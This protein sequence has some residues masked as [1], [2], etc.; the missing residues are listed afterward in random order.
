MAY[1]SGSANNFADLLT[2]LAT[3]C[4]A[5][6]WAWNGGILSKDAAFL[7]L[8]T[9]ANGILIQGGTSQTGA[10][11]NGASAHTPRLGRLHSTLGA[12]PV[13]PMAYN[14]HIGTS[15]D[16]V[17]LIARHNVDYFYWLAFG[18]SDVPGLPGTGAWLG[19]IAP[20]DLETFTG[21]SA[22]GGVRIGP[23]GS[24]GDTW[25]GGLG[26]SAALFWKT[27]NIAT[28]RSQNT[29]HCS[30]DGVAWADH[31]TSAG[32][33][34]Q[35]KLLAAAQAAPHIAR[36]PSAWNSEAPLIPI[37]AYYT[38]ASAKMSLV[39]DLKHARYLRVD[40]YDPEQVI[41][42]GSDQWRVYPFYRKNTTQR[43]GQTAGGLI[44]HTGTFGW[45]IRYD[46]P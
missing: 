4:V 25:Q 42:L 12:Q 9:I 19:A 18:V 16:E 44:D 36:S 7:K 24:G 40:N 26:S 33:D 2:A 11:L 45:A 30:L 27:N 5:E 37:Q 29:L 15:P 46:G 10:T 1:Y 34:A 21:G 38:R 39:A 6:G 22:T 41:T 43:D 13:W 35:G 8:S 14:I 23:E 20:A 31:P 28:S 17:Y 3:A 32:P